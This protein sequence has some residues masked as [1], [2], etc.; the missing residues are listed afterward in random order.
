MFYRTG[1]ILIV[2]IVLLFI[3]GSIAQAAPPVPDNEAEAVPG[4]SLGETL[5]LNN[6]GTIMSGRD[7]GTDDDANSGD[8]ADSDSDTADGSGDDTSGDAANSDDNGDIPDDS[9]GDSVKEHPVASAMAQYFAD[10]LGLSYQELYDE[11]MEF[12]LAGNGFGAIAKAYFLAD[13]LTTPL[14]PQELLEAAHD[15]GWGNVLKA[16]GIHPGSVGNGGAHSNRPDQAANSDQ[17]TQDGPPGQL[18]KNNMAEP[19]GSATLVGPGSG[20]NQ[21]GQGNGHGNGQDKNKGGNGNNG[22]GHG[23]N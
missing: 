16:G 22:R 7:S 15:S 2:M 20:N 6:L 23:R 17:V 21:N 5:N 11:I 19:I 18:K 12:H 3:L 14:T 4:S 1:L 13:K 10:D 8:P 9:T